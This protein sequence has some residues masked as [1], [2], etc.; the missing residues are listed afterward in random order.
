MAFIA[1]GNSR[2]QRTV[3]NLPGQPCTI[4]TGIEVTDIGFQCAGTNRKAVLHTHVVLTVEVL[5]LRKLVTHGHIGSELVIPTGI[6]KLITF[7]RAFIRP[8]LTGQAHVLIVHRVALLH[9]IYLTSRQSQ[10]LDVTGSQGRALET[11]G[12]QPAAV[13]LQR[14]HVGHQVTDVQITLGEPHL[15]SDAQL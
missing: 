5:Q 15:A 6:A 14:G 12:K 11:L 9:L 2:T 3:I 7:C 4:F 1:V 8:V 13:G 10:V